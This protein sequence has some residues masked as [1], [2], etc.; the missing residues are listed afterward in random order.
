MAVALP[1]MTL[2]LAGYQVYSGE[3]AADEQEDLARANAERQRM[4]SDEAVR[5]LSAR[6]EASES[7]AK[8]IAAA[9]GVK[10]TGSV[11]DYLD[12]MQK[13]NKDEVSWLRKSGLS[14]E[15]IMARE[16]QLQA[17]MTRRGSRFKAAGSFLST[18]D[19]AGWFE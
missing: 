10:V 19:E 4:E 11:T 5:R 18:V 7:Q 15:S 8:A 12:V 17:D 6:Q 14:A 1:Y 13:T 16:G 3:R 9:S 2:A